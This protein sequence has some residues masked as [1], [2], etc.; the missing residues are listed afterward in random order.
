MPLIFYIMNTIEL[1]R[2]YERDMDMLIMEEF[3]SD[4]AFARLFLDKINLDDNYSIDRISHSLSNEN[5]ESDITII[6]QY[7]D[8]KVALLIEDKITAPTMP[9]Q[10]ERYF[11]RADEAK[12]RGDYESYH[13][14]LVAP[15]A[16]ISAHAIDINANY[17][18]K[19]TYEELAEFFKG[20]DP[21][22]AVFKYS[23]ISNALNEKEHHYVVNEN[24][25]VTKFWSALRTL[26]KEWYPHLEMLGSDTP[27]GASAAWP[28]FRTSCG[29]IKVVYKSTKGYVD[30]E[31]PRY[32]DRVADLESKIQKHIK[33]PMFIHQSGKSASLRLADDRWQIN[34]SDDF[35][36]HK[37]VIYEV[38]DAVSKMCLLASKI[39]YSD[40]Y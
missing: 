11:K 29:K 18:N 5:G 13:I 25:C 4:K 3:I 6:L 2:V 26:C 17:P 9:A 28:E 1:K 36:Q 21:V 15:S 40:L 8:N 27:K 22:R 31:F 20:K 37:I 14:F 32:G 35:N 7:P 24:I 23:V 39:N 12:K 34:F 30:L 16:Y 38:L 19:I 10:S 33:P